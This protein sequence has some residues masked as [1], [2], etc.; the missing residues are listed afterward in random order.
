MAP[1]RTFRRVVLALLVLASF[2]A[3]YAAPLGIAL[4]RSASPKACCPKGKGAHCSRT[5]H[6]PGWTAGNTH[7]GGGCP[8]AFATAPAA[9][10]LACTAKASAATLALGGI[11]TSRPEAATKSSSYPAFL[12]QRPPP[13]C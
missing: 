10:A 7:C 2:C 12:Y 4:L 5:S 9:T 11:S 1:L 13:I 8:G 6:G 3:A